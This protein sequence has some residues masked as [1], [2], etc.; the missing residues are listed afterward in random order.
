[1]K[2]KFRA[3]KYNNWNI[4]LNGLTQQQ[5]G[6]DRGISELEDRKIKLHNPHNREKTDWQKIQPQRPVDL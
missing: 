2:W 5:N 1:M 6:V 3:E 4:K